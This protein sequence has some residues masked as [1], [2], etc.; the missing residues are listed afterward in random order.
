[1]ER[2][3]P[4]FVPEWYKSSTSSASGSSSA[5]HHSGSSSHLDEHRVGHASRNRLLLS[6]SEHDAPRSS[7]LL[8]RSSLSFRRSASSNGSMSHD[9]DSPLHSRTYGSFGRC[10]RD[11]D[12]EKDIDLRDRDRSHL[13]DN[14][15]C[16]YSDSF[17]GSRSGKDTL[18]RSHSMVSGKQVESL[19][20]RLGN[21][22]KNGILSGASIISGISKTSFERDFPSL[23]AEEK[24][25][26]PEIGRVSSPGLSS[27]IQ[28]L[29]KGIG[30]NGWTSALVDIPMKVGGNGPVPSSTS[31]TS[32]T[33][34]SNASSSST[35]LNMAETL[36]QAPSRVRSP[37]QLSVDTQRIEERTR[38]QYSK[39]IPVTPSTTKSLALSSSEKSKTKGVRSGDLS[40]ASKVGQQS[41]QFVNLT[42]RAPARTDTQKVSQVG[43]FQVLN[44]ERNGISP[45]AKDAPSLM[46]PSR[47]ATPLS[48]VQTTSIPAPKSPVK[49]KLKADSKAGSPSSTHSSFG[50]KRPTSQA[51]NRND[52]FNFIRKKTP[53]NH[54]ADLPEPSC[55]AS[56]CSAK[57]GEQITGTSTS[58]NKEQGSSASCFDSERPVENGDGVT[59]CGGDACELPSRAH[60]DNDERSSSSVP[61]VPDSGPGNVGESSSGPVLAPVFA[62]D[63]V[64][65]CPSSDPLVVPSEEELD[66]LR[67]LGWDENAEGDALTPEE[68]NDFVRQ[69]EARITS[70]RT[71]QR[72][73]RPL[74]MVLPDTGQSGVAGNRLD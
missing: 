48:G 29:P 24:P 45:T 31:Q 16:D 55:V 32:A 50:E 14:G 70:L 46:N 73:I 39:L 6:V 35:G 26:P 72:E 37:P 7:V 63:N 71:G 10:H 66:L 3:E 17:M 60:P 62:P 61:V 36:A 8:D 25:G 44:R 57:L 12:R 34:G 47:V 4:T 59:E 42:L 53:A 18:R 54:S 33:P 2:G 58:V 38:I 68:I 65:D 21:D 9:K 23:G 30:G 49:P 51:Q 22:L 13:A 5:N 69:H 27:A 56:S 40:G 19:P 43:N 11:R 74:R 52:F 28:N 41:S 20:R 15:F 67:R 1:M 64:D